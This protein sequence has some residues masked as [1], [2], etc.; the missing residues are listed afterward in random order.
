MER[1]HALRE[2]ELFA[3]YHGVGSPYWVP[4]QSNHPDDAGPTNTVMVLDGPDGIIGTLR[5]DRLPA[6]IGAV[7]LVAVDAGMAGRGLGRLMTEQLVTL[8]EREGLSSLVVNAQG[9]AAGFY[10]KMGFRRSVWPGMSADVRAVPMLLPLRVPH[11]ADLQ[12]VL[13]DLRDFAVA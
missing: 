1:V 7:R 10:V 5:L 4:Y 11:D 12:T 8:A 2:R 13:S 3:R 9:E 6:R